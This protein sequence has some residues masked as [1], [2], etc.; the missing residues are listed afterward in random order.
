M[1]T[2]ATASVAMAALATAQVTRDGIP[3]HFDDFRNS[4][5]V[6][7]GTMTVNVD[8]VEND[9][10]TVPGEAS[11]FYSND[12]QSTWTE[13]QM[14]EVLPY[15]GGT[16]EAS[17][18]V[19]DGDVH[20]YFVAHDDGSATFSSPVNSGD[21]FPAPMNL[22]TNP[23]TETGGD[24]SNPLNWSLDLDGF[25]V[26]YSDTCLYGRL[27]NVTGSW[28]TA[29][30]IFGPWFI[31]TLVVDNPDAGADSF[32][33]AM[34][35]GN[36]P[37]IAASGL[38]FVDARDSSYT[39]IA[40]IDCQISGGDLNM[41]CELA[42]LYAHPYFGADNPS[43]YYNLGAGTATVWLANLGH[44]ADST[45]VHS[46]YRRTE[47]GAVGTNTAPHLD[48][49]GYA[50][51]PEQGVNGAVVTLGATYS[52]ADGHLPTIRQAVVDGSPVE[53]GSGPDHDYASGVEFL[54]DVDLTLE[55]HTFYFRFSDGVETVETPADTIPLA[56]GAPDGPTDSTVALRSMW[57]SPMRGEST[58]VFSVPRGSEGAL[59]VYDVSGRLV[60]SLWR[61]AGGDHSRAWNGRD[62]AGRLVPSG[63][64]FVDLVSTVGRDRARLVLL[65]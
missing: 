29:H 54:V 35:Y 7:Y 48:A 4:A 56:S 5:A 53:M 6:P 26:G 8:I 11:V 28:P 16:W 40:D 21:V 52:D 13:V 39:R 3:P 49:P 19:E 44:A 20:Y 12:G 51:S 14:S 34:V 62:E 1:L 46:Y 37:L 38:Y 50:F 9:A 61:G 59:S 58:I 60:R 55:D 17:F 36:V 57:P 43:G 45:C 10:P 63:V 30:T 64:Y 22:M 65:R 47:V 15:A 31:Y 2:L 18:P 25:W 23:G 32:A 41:R 42:D 33:Y 24:I 27:S